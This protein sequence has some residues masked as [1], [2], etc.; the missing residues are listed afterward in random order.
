MDHHSATP[1]EIAATAWSPHDTTPVTVALG[2]NNAAKRKAVEL[3]SWSAHVAIPHPNMP[4]HAVLHPLAHSLFVS[5][6]LLQAFASVFPHRPLSVDC[7]DVASGVVPQPLTARDT[8]TGATNR[9]LAAQHSFRTRHSRL[10]DFSIGVEGGIEQVCDTHLEC[11][12]IVCRHSSGRV[13]VGRSASYEVSGAMM[14]RLA[15]GR[16]LGDVIDELSGETDVRQREGMM[17]IITNSVLP[18]AE[19]Y[20]HGVIFA[21]APFV[22]APV[23]WEALPVTAATN[24]TR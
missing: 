9:S 10:P 24:D 11:G 18:R 6:L 17:G 2:T 15:D 22:S 19:C 21:L 23:Y 20:V 16:E 8:L 4:S 7:F 12:Y 5:W 1:G 3:V 13:G 14:S